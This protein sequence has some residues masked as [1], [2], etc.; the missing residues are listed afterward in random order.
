MMN[1][2][3]GMLLGSLVLLWGALIALRVISEPEP[4]HVPLKFVSGQTVAREDAHAEA[5]VPEVTQPK[6]AGAVTVAFK[7]PKN[8]FAPLDTRTDEE[9][10]EA[11]R[12]R[13]LAAKKVEV[14]PAPP[15]PPPPTPEELAA[16]EARRQEELARQQK[17]Q[18]IQQARNAMGQYRFL[19]YLTQAGEHRAFLGKENQIFIVRAGETVEGKIH[20]TAIDAT[21]VKLIEQTTNVETSLPLTKDGS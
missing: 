11:A 6:Q 17:E 15:A 14:P 9:K 21:T 12:A 4:Q 2:S 3:K 19:G 5:G 20:V 16:Q 1:R 10:Q 18:A 13:L 7:T 8:I